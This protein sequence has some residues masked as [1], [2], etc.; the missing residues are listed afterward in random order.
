MHT[1]DNIQY[2]KNTTLQ[3][4]IIQQTNRKLQTSGAPI[5]KSIELLVTS[6]V[7][8]GTCFF[9]QKNLRID[10]HAVVRE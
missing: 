9:Q 6:L 1:N 8:Q 2:H 3:Q 4:M 5:Y 10:H 7:T